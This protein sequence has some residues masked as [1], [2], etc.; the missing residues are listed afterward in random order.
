MRADYG[1][2]SENPAFARKCTEAGLTF[3]G[4]P[5]QAI[6]SMGSKRYAPTTPP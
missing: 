5:W 2:L 6:E 3:I 4:P 1:Q